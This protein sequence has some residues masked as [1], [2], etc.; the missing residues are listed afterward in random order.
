M[1]APGRQIFGG[2]F[3]EARLKSHE[4]GQTPG[5]GDEKE[6]G[7]DQEGEKNLIVSLKHVRS[8]F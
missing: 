2:H 3:D 5:K 8:L 1:L 4:I 6:V 7:N